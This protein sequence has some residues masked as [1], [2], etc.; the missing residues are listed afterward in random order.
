MYARTDGNPK[1]LHLN[2]NMA[3]LPLDIFGFIHMS[4]GDILD[5][6]LVGLLIFFVL[7][8]IHSSSAR[9]IVVAVIAI[10]F[11]MILADALNMKMSSKI[12]SVFLDVGVIALIVI[13]Q[14]EIRHA[15][16]RLGS[17][18]S[19]GSRLF[20]LV[21]KVLGQRDTQL[22]NKSVNE[23]AE[24]VNTMSDNKTG[25]LIVIPHEVRLGDIV[26]NEGVKIDADINRFLILNIFFKNSP[27]HDGA[28]ILE[29]DR[30]MYA[31]AQ[32]P[33]TESTDMPARFGMRHKAA[34]GLSENSDADVIV[35]S[36]ET[37]N[38]HLVKNG[39]FHRIRSMVQLKRDLGIALGQM[40]A[41]ALKE[42]PAQDGTDTPPGNDKA[43]HPT[44]D[45][46]Q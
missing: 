30:I 27:L 42:H 5:V 12:A 33:M 17:G 26:I 31:G 19:F 13:F 35:V 4:F 20:V 40:E 37:G 28:M 39:Q 11:I 24:A 21:R 32:L 6:L 41:D 9:S 2:R 7:R 36:E 44:Q 22:D 16:M 1:D 8:W 18:N 15:L 45:T 29:G 46:R 25:A 23:I 43:N 14:P 3:P 34:I 38:V 10:F